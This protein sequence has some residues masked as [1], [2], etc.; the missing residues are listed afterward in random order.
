MGARKPTDY[1]KRTETR[2][3]HSLLLE[4][5]PSLDVPKGRYDAEMQVYVR[6]E[7]GAPAFVDAFL[8]TAAGSELT[9]HHSTNV[10]G[11]PPFSDP[12]NG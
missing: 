5:G 1:R 10:S 11:A 3:F 2:V 9:T 8:A 4:S 6:E 7:D 12:D